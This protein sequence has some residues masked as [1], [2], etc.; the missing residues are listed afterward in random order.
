MQD[1]LIVLDPSGRVVRA[2][3]AGGDYAGNARATME[4]EL[5]L[6]VVFRS[7]LPRHPRGSSGPMEGR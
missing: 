3:T 1:G 4:G 5:L 6:H 7:R 2:K